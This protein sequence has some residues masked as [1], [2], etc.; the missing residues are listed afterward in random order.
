MF[1][2]NTI[3]GSLAVSC[4]C[5]F[6]A[7]NAQD[8]APIKDN[9]FFIEEAYN[10]EPGVIQWIATVQHFAD[11]VRYWGLSLTQEFPLHGMR[12]QLSWTVPA[13]DSY[14]QDFNIGRIALHYR[15]QVLD[16]G[17][18]VAMSPRG[19]MLLPTDEPGIVGTRAIEWQ[20]NVPL[21][22][23]LSSGTTVHLNAGITYS[24]GNSV[25]SRLT[26]TLVKDEEFTSY[27]FGGSIVW[28]AHANANFLFEIL[29]ASNEDFGL[30]YIP[31]RVGE[32]ILNPGVRIAINPSFGQFVPGIGV[33]IRM[34]EGETDIG[35]FGYLSFEHAL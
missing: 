21:S 16:G 32:T 30:E 19:S 4:T 14:F 2:K 7:A 29:H 12:H 6:G 1:N 5:L 8:S 34:T 11:P 9:S 35:I 22:I 13:E 27:F 15:A 18:G 10:Q 3:V 25:D 28:L 17:N 31:E 26:E 23:E 24:P 33:P 20:F